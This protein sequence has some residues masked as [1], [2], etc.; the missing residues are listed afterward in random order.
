[1]LKL[2]TLIAASIFT[3]EALV[4]LYLESFGSQL[5]FWSRAF[6]DA[7]LL[8]VCIFPTLSFL[9]FKEMT[10]QISLR[11][12]AEETQRSWNQ[13]LELMVLE[14]A[15]RLQRASEELLV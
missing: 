7:S 6:L 3:T 12:Q 1:M 14:R 8:P 2:I 9:V 5:S 10:E 13:S 4:M 11:H 15:E